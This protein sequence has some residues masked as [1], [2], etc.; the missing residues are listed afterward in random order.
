[1]RAFSDPYFPVNGQNRIE[2]CPY[3]GKYRSAKA[4]IS[5]FFTHCESKEL[6]KILDANSKMVIRYI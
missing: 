2:F 4:R 5:G 3:A 1:M 6:Y